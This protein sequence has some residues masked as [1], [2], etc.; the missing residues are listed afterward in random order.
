MKSKLVKAYMKTAETFAELSHAKRLHVGAIVVKDDRII[1]IGYNGMPAG[2][3]NN[4]ENRV[5]ANEWSIDNAHW[6]YQE[7]DGT[8][9]NLKTKPEVLH[10]E[11]NA[12][13]KLARSTESGYGA[14]L[15]VTHSPCLD[16]AKLIYQ[17]GIKTV[18]YG[19]AYRNNAGIEFLEKSGVEVNKVE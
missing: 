16:C 18:Y 19:N 6:D 15:F 5:Y 17:S 8:A 4:C 10:A 7:E 3:D 1:S 14:D 12:I 9:Y 2:W 13:A 11:T